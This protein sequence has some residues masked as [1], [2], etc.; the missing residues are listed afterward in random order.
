M[1]VAG[2]VAIVP[3][4]DFDA[5]IT[6]K[7]LDMVL[8]NGNSYV[9][10][11]G[12]KGNLPTDTEFW[13]KSTEGTKVEI[14]TAEKAGI[15]KPD[16]NTITVDEDGT[17]HGSASVDVATSSAAGIVKPDNDTIK[18]SSDG[19]IKSVKAGFT[20]TMEEYETA[21]AAGEIKDGTIVNITDDYTE[22]ESGETYPKTTTIQTDGTIVE[23]VGSNTITTTKT[24]SENA[25]TFVEVAKDTQTEETISTITTTITKNPDGTRTIQE[26]KS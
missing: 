13:M 26:V 1:A 3:K 6:Y 10:K 20:G 8:Y 18:V 15:V 9:A 2:R 5:T 12:T 4:D 17:L 7:R 22:S 25:T 24:K 21:N 16:G 14:A 19:T 23:Q 11:K